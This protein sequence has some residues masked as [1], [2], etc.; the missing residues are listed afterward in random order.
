MFLVH[1]NGIPFANFREMFRKNVLFGILWGG[2]SGREIRFERFE[3]EGRNL[4]PG[5]TTNPHC[6]SG[7]T[8]ELHKD[9]N[10]EKTS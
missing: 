7:M 9:C 8:V 4:V 1:L 5:G 3:T 10:G 6:R 2:I